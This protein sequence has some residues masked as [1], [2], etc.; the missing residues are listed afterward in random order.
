MKLNSTDLLLVLI[1][2]AV[3]VKAGYDH[4]GTVEEASPTPASS[5]VSG[6]PAPLNLS[7]QNGPIRIGDRVPDFR[8]PASLPGESFA[9]EGRGEGSS[10]GSPVL[11][12]LTAT[13]CGECL[14]RVDGIDR[15]AYALAKGVGA[16]VWNFLVYEAATGVPD[17]IVRRGP[18]A[19]HVVADPESKVSVTTLGGSD[20]QCWLLIDRK[21]RLAWRGPAELEGLRTALAQI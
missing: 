5:V 11:I 8:L 15:E 13:G 21:G 17:F 10:E 3:L 2:V 7:A 18:S 4:Q 1:A 9:Y 14:G 16:E 6:E 12:V 20:T 19:D